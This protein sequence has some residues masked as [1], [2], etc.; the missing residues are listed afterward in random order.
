VGAGLA[1]ISR[2]VTRPTALAI[3]GNRGAGS[4]E[5][6]AASALRIALRGLG[7]EVGGG[8]AVGRAPAHLR[9]LS[10]IRS[11]TLA[12]LV[13]SQN[14]DSVNFI[15][16]M[17]TKALGARVAGAGSTAGHVPYAR[18]RADRTCARASETVRACPIEIGRARSPW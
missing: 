9:R 8:A 2:H 15:A 1:G 5:L 16:E 6:R 12:S 14:H 18:G 10:G 17:L 11:A 13:R 4:P 3:D 7:V